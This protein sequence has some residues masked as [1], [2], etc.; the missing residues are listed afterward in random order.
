[1]LLPN[2]YK[3]ANKRDALAEHHFLFMLHC[4]LSCLLYGDWA[5]RMGHSCNSTLQGWERARRRAKGGPKSGLRFECVL[6]WYETS[7]KLF[8]L[9][10]LSDRSAVSQPP[11]KSGDVMGRNL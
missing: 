3:P 4:R 1:M 11:F 10:V 6:R 8:T 5:L 2:R 9:K 7:G